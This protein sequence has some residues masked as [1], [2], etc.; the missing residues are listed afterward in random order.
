[1]NILLEAVGLNKKFNGNTTVLNNVC[2]KIRR[3]GIAALIGE[4]GG[5]KTTL[6]RV[7]TGL[8]KASSGKVLFK[9]KEL[10]T[11][12]GRS[13]DD[14][15]SLQ[16]IFQDPYA[17]LEEESTVS[18]VLQE[19]VNMCSR[20]GRDYMPPQEA[21][22][23]A[24]L[25]GAA[26]LGR[27]IKTLSG[28]QRQRVSLARSLITRPDLIIADECTAMLD[29]QA[30]A[31]IGRIFKKLNQKL[32]LSF[33]IVTHDAQFLYQVVDY[34]YVLHEGAIVEAG[35]K[36]RGLNIPSAGYTR[37]YME[38]MWEIEGGGLIEQDHLCQPQ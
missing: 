6:C 16:Y 23:W 38:S 10:G 18:S 4:S 17:A 33:L 21:L 34:I 25:A 37:E 1:M 2:L 15:A 7:F 13:F 9:G 22:T 32:G 27:K 12:R 3:G 29:A 8:E 36:D 11:L 31:E 35:P 14:C 26:F 30:A 19:P 24:G 20:R 28:G 5:G